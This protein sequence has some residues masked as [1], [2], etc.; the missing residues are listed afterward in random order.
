[1]SN[2]NLAQQEKSSLLLIQKRMEHNNKELLSVSNSLNEERLSAFKKVDLRLAS[3]ISFN[4]D[5]DS[6]PS[7]II[8]ING[9]LLAGHKITKSV[10]QKIEISDVFS[11]LKID[12]SELNDFSTTPADLNN[13]IFSD[14]KFK[15]EFKHLYQYYKD[16][17]FHQFIK[18]A[19]S[20]FVLFKTGPE[21]KDIKVYRW[22]IDR[23]SNYQY[24]GETQ[25]GV[26]HSIITNN[27]IKLSE[28]V[29]KKV[30]GSIEI[31][32]DLLVSNN[33]GKVSFT[34]EVKGI[35]LEEDLRQKN[36]AIEDVKI[37]KT[38][39]NDLTL[40]KFIPYNEEPRFY[41][42]DN[43]AQNIIRTSN[44]E[45][46]IQELPEKNGVLFSNGYYLND[47]QFKEFNKLE[48][49]YHYM[50][51]ASPNGEDSL[52]IFY[53]INSNDYLIYNYNIVSK[54]VVAPVTA[55]GFTLLDNGGLI[56][57][58]KT[59][60][61]AKIHHIQVWESV[62]F[63][64]T[65]YNEMQKNAVE[66]RISKIGNS[67][68]VKAIG[69]INSVVN[70]IA[71]KK[72]EVSIYQ[73]II[74]MVD[75]ILDTYHWLSNFS[76]LNINK[77]LNETKDTAQQVINEFQ[78]VE[79]LKVFA[80]NK[81]KTAEDNLATIDRN[82]R[83]KN[84]DL[85]HM[86]GSL[87]SIKAFIGQATTLKDERYI[88]IP[89]VEKLIEEAE[90][91]RIFVNNCI[92]NLLDQPKTYDNLTNS[93]KELGV[94]I[95]NENSYKKV[96]EYNLS[97]DDI[98]QKLSILNQ[99]IN[100][101][102]FEDNSLLSE[103]LEKI[104]A[105]FSVVNQIKSRG[106]QK[107]QKLAFEEAKVEFSS[108]SKLL[109]QTLK[110][111]LNNADTIQK[112]ETE[113]SKTLVLLQELEAR[114]SEFNTEEFTVAISK[115]REDIISA[116]GSH[117]QKVRGELQKKTENLVNAIKISLRSIQN[118]ASQSQ[119]V[120]EV[121]SIFLTDGIV[122]RCKKLILQIR[123]LGDISMSEDLSG[124]LRKIEKDAIKKVRDDLDLFDSNGTVLK[125]GSYRFAVNK[126]PF[127]VVL[128]K[129]DGKVF[130]HI[131]TTDYYKEV[132]LSVI[133]THLHQFWNYDFISESAN[134]YR[135]E[136]LAF[137]I[138]QDIKNNK[139]ELNN[140]MVFDIINKGSKNGVTY[141]LLNL[142]QDYSS[143]LYK[144]GYIK[145]IHDND[146]EAIIKAILNQQEKSVDLNYNSL[147]RLVAWVIKAR[148]DLTNHQHDNE[149][150]ED[151]QRGLKLL[152]KINS[153]LLLNN[154]VKEL[155]IELQT[156]R[157][158]N[159]D[160]FN[161]LVNHTTENVKTSIQVVDFYNN[162]YE[163]LGEF[164][165]DIKDSFLEKEFFEDKMTLIENTCSL[166][167]AYCEHHNL[168][169]SLIN[170]IVIYFVRKEI[171]SHDIESE[172]IEYLIQIDNLFG[173]HSN[174]NNG[175]LIF[176]TEDFNLRNKYHREHIIPAYEGVDEFKRKTLDDEKALI[177]INGF[178]SKPLTS[179]VKNKLISDS[180]F[181]KFGANL[182]KQ[183]GE[184]G[185]NR[186]SDTM[187]ML[188]LTSPPGYGKTTLV[189]YI[190]NKLG[191]VFVKINCP[192]IG[193]NVTSL[194]PNDAPDLTARKEIEKINLSFEM[195][196]NVCLYLDDIQH[197]NPEF[198]QK[199]IPLCDGT[200]TVEGVW[201]GKSKTYNLR[202]KR[203][204]V[205]MAGNPYTENGESF[206]IPD[207]LANRADTYNLGD[208]SSD[209]RTVFEM[210]YIENAI[211][212]NPTTEPLT[213]RSMK[214]VYLF[215]KMVDG[216]EID[217][218]EFDYEYSA[219]E[220]EEILK[221]LRM[222]KNVQKIV[223]KVNEQYIYS[224]SQS[225]NYRNEPPFKLQGSY[226]NMSKIVEKILPLMTEQEIKNLIMDHYQAESQT[227]TNSNEENLLKFKEIFGIMND[228]EKI[229]WE[230]LKVTFKK[231]NGHNEKAT[232]QEISDS[233]AK[234]AE[235]FQK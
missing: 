60:V 209:D 29:S 69:S 131:E 108:H 147:D 91:R 189:E 228:K 64:D 200:R 17:Q 150:V 100:S 110:N 222:M 31:K 155:Q 154:A 213:N 44:Y 82:S 217:K 7:D 89:V 95:D 58:R 113:Y 105:V 145:G 152:H 177:N 65:Y 207:M 107:E 197:T 51:Y 180:Y 216:V 27:P 183:I 231:L 199:F 117:K 53:N 66:N 39:V 43:I 144:E 93:I 142:V 62:F 25:S 84:E 224:A 63:A 80:K 54:T 156:E 168:T 118:K 3:T 206:K 49:S 41:I 210:S 170:E 153:P 179:F 83:T 143:K 165:V 114:F 13:S 20:M 121:T 78:K 194:D 109:E 223:L 158:F 106:K 141:N 167:E 73:T 230:E 166:V 214:D 97:M 57:L 86:L 151:I 140:Q 176:T 24:V 16:V 132:D 201:N 101:L 208:I 220:M 235:N 190:V 215:L 5:T 161:Y 182:A 119:N 37:F 104:A 193:H 218:A 229:R 120:E 169:K 94:S 172:K 171:L 196:N 52:V 40:I 1:M 26:L 70:F 36:Q 34:H 212:S 221:V 202:N 205:I 130:T 81:V 185:E 75:S 148:I 15:D 50:T 233:L 90:K 191:M 124:Q 134:L 186:K 35:L 234:I 12:N 227:L 18:N 98:V 96:K 162:M 225:N 159:I 48:E 8:N 4:S 173:E 115:Q 187:G 174:I 10:V 23:H 21:I 74:K 122:L 59:D 116:F 71:N 79:E 138:L 149:I 157:L 181:P 111:S 76:D 38:Q 47:G 92:I 211:V 184:T 137:S 28:Q 45:N 19:N 164:I 128:I 14:N 127:E 11:Y 112:I 125:L 188:L 160:T 85:N 22:D 56:L 198:L 133:D 103:I 67:E 136:Y 68:V 99:E 203:F 46:S 32:S 33:K 192:S 77:T 178:K 175:S 87:V 139:N 30:A 163:E 2:D 55:Q 102:D 72:V 195:G 146:A 204:S 9:F 135:S 88:D 42:F 232:M 226:R 6:L 126:R 219:I 123:E 61:A 129:R